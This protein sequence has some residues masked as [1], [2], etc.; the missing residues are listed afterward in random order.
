M[1]IGDTQHVGSTTC[2]F[3]RRCKHNLDRSWDITNNTWGK[4]HQECEFSQPSNCD[5]MG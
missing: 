4:I 1:N 5:V 3:M 2:F